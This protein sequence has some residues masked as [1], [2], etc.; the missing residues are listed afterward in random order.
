MRLFALGD[1]LLCLEMQPGTIGFLGLPKP[2]LKLRCGGHLLGG[3]L[4]S[5][6]LNFQEGR[7]GRTRFLEVKPEKGFLK[8]SSSVAGKLSHS[9]EKLGDVKGKTSLCTPRSRFLA[10]GLK[11][12]FYWVISPTVMLLGSLRETLPTFL[13]FDRQRG[14][15]S[16]RE[17]LQW[18]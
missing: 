5:T 10:S 6:F 7:V 18:R 9:W 3:C 13:G 14:L 4:K 15:W 12:S 8:L 2:R 1:C 16:L 17:G 11:N